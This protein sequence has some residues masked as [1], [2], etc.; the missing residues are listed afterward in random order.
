MKLANL[1]G[2]AV[3]LRTESSGVDVQRAS[4]G[5]FG[6]DLPSVLERWEEFQ[7]WARAM[8]GPADVAVVRQNLGPPSP[9]PRQILAIGLNYH[10]HATESGF[11]SPT[12][13]P[14]TFTKFVTSL[15]GPDTIVTL[16]PSGHTDWEVELVVV[17]GREAAFVEESQAWS[18]VAGLT[19]GQDL[20]ERITQLRGPAPQFSLG[21]SYAGFA[22]TGPWLVTIDELG[23]P[24]D[25]ELGCNINGVAVQKARTKDLIYP[26]TRLVADLSRTVT[27][28]P[29]DLIFSG[30]PSGVGQGRSPQRFL[31]PGEHLQSYIE[32]LGELHQT[33]VAA[34]RSGA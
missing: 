1:D 26:V 33:F 11:D 3:I 17:I 13:L 12:E 5:R 24:N 16:P 22:P 34:D 18:Y 29:G 31:E 15:T 4:S 30:T 19:V 27:L 6:P 23:D 8:D 28:L 32:G 25:L 14:P 7:A 20:S 2:R 21:K 9:V 10:D